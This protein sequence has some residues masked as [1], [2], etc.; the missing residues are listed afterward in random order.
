MPQR[1]DSLPRDPM[2]ARLLARFSIADRPAIA[3][4]FAVVLLVIGLSAAGIEQTSS[5]APAQGEPL[6]TPGPA[7]NSKS[8]LMSAARQGDDWAVARLIAG[9]TDINAANAN[10]GTA[11]M[12]AAIKGDA[13]ISEMLLRAGA[14]TDPKA[15]LGWTALS[16]AAV[17]GHVDV[18]Q[19]LLAGGADPNIRDT[20]G[21][22]P[23]MR[24]ADRRRAGV[25]RLLL[26]VG[27]IDTTIRQEAGSTA[28]H[29]AAAV[30]D[31]D[32]VRMLVAHGADRSARDSYDNTPAAIARS[33]G[34]PEIAEYLEA[35]GATGAT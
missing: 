26:D 32:I 22:T 16:L 29:I 24:A 18:V 13:K 5:A 20:Y 17:K 31:V 10:G 1:P 7:A 2:S 27:N 19:V 6:I 8:P 34:H 25:V 23:L 12:F 4:R 28:L 33:A 14:R 35:P 15:K 21:W 9:G 30:G 3:G 11:L